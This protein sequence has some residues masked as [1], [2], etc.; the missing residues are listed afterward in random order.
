MEDLIQERVAKGKEVKGVIFYHN[1][2]N[3]GMKSDGKLMLAYSE[4]EVVGSI[5]TVAVGQRIVD[6]CK[7]LGL[8][9]KW[10]GSSHTRIEIQN[11]G[12]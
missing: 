12:V 7:E 2:D 11:A 5:D 10:D 8:D 3:T 1:Q 6:L 4:S 9:V